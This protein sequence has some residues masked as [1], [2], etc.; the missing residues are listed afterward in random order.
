MD[1][2]FFG[3][4]GSF[5]YQN[6][7]GTNSMIRRLS[8]EIIGR[9]NNKV[10]YI[11]YGGEN[12]EIKHQSNFFS[13]Y[14]EN[15]GD[16]LLQLKN[17]D[18]VII[19]YFPPLDVLPIKKFL[20]KKN[21]S[22]FFH[23]LYLEWP[24]SIIK[25]KLKFEL[26]KLLPI[27]GIS[28]TISYRLFNYVK[29]WDKRVILFFPPVSQ[30]FFIPLTEKELPG[31]I[32]VTF[33]GRIDHGK[34]VP[35]VI[36]LFK[37][38]A[39]RDDIELSFYGIHWEHDTSVVALHNYLITQKLFKFV[40]VPFKKW[41]PD[42]DLMVQSALK[43]TDIFLQPY[44]KL[45]S[46]IDTPLLLLEAMASLCPVVTK[47]Y[48]NIPD[49]YPSTRCIIDDKHFWNN[50]EPLINSAHEW[51]SDEWKLINKQNKTLSFDTKSI[52]DTF[53]RALQNVSEG[54]K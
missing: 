8:T 27:N 32:R 53:I 34:G 43:Q 19:I 35:D 21:G 44:Q 31:K 17:Y 11:L 25:R 10:D 20:S 48:G 2:A 54:V 23:I 16:A 12:K 46:T 41:T 50:I 13:R 36:K 39:Q 30:D 14:Y 49:L 51:M 24:E 22:T 52:C 9:G 5:D 1:I 4:H 28:F 15:L 26:G 3:Y 45:S 33:I 40:S 7:G 38:L 47:P 29:Q 6:I 42:T 37:K 18:H